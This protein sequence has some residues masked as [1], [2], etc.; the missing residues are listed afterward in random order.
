MSKYFGSILG[1][2]QQAPGSSLRMLVQVPA[3]GGSSRLQQAEDA[4]GSSRRRPVEVRT[5]PGARPARRCHK[6]AVCGVGAVWGGGPVG[7]QS[8]RHRPTRHHRQHAREDPGLHRGPGGGL[9]GGLPAVRHEGR[10]PDPGRGAKVR[11]VLAAPQPQDTGHTR[12]AWC[13]H[14]PRSAGTG[15][16][17]TLAHVHI[18]HM[19]A[20][21]CTHGEEWSHLV[22]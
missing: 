16:R 9:Q 6:K 20:C 7:R 8:A 3:C 22:L 11:A 14:T 4:T 18:A 13:I 21:T 15:C 2:V 17:Y 19:G 12:S 5:R 1:H 10:R